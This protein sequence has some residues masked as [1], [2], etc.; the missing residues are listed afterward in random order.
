MI[1]YDSELHTERDDTLS[2]PQSSLDLFCLLTVEATPDAFSQPLTS[3]AANRLVNCHGCLNLRTSKPCRDLLGR[4][5][6]EIS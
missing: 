6:L 3:E 4:K 1:R 5:S 2:F